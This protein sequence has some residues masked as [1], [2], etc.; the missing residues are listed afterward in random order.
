MKLFIKVGMKYPGDY[1]EAICGLTIGYY[2]PLHS[3]QTLYGA[4]D[5][6]IVPIPGGFH[7]PVVTNKL[8]FGTKVLDYLYGKTNGRYRLPLFGILWK[9]APYFW[10]YLFAFMYLI[11][12][13]KPGNL[14]VLLFPLMY[15][16]TCFLGPVSYMRYIFIN[17]AAF[18]ILIY[19]MVA[20][21]TKDD[22]SV[23]EQQ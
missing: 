19:L 6:Y 13:K 17:V 16:L 10:T 5:L 4:N 3:P 12:K 9:G 20:K 7:S 15:M 18:P 1:L 23:T 11:Y 22:D 8:P 2:M 21:D 14:C